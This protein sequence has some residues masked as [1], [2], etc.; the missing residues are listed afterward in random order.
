MVSIKSI[1][2][3]FLA[4]LMSA[5]DSDNN[6]S[7][8]KAYMRLNDANVIFLDVRTRE[9]FLQDGRIQNSV[10]I[11]LDKL[12]DSHNKIEQYIDKEIFVYC[13]SGRRSRIAT[14]YLNEQGFR[15]YNLIGGFLAWE[16]TLSQIN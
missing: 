1:S 6:I 3:I 11:P 4:F 8:G 14:R 16:K 2:I 10:L 12:K 9:E 5:C 13:R 7:A 15:A